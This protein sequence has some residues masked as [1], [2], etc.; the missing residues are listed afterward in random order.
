MPVTAVS[1]PNIALIKYWGNRNDDLRMPA[2]DSLSMTLDRPSVAV[3]VEAADV[4]RVRSFD[5]DGKERVLTGKQ[6]ARFAETLDLVREYLRTIHADEALPR[7][8]SITVRSHIP[9]SVGLASSAAVFSALARALAGLMR[10]HTPLTDAQVSVLARLG[11]GSA[12]RSI[13]GGYAALLAGDGDG[14]GASYGKHIAP[15][16]HW[17]L[18]DFV[19]IPSTEAKKVGSTEGH[20]LAQ[21]SP[22]FAQRIADIM[23]RRQPQCIDAVLRRDFELLRNVTEEDALDMHAVM[24]SSVPPLRYLSEETHRI[25]REITSLREEKHLP[26]LYTM[27]AGPTVHLL[28]EEGAVT[29][30]RHFA[31]AQKERGC[32]I[33]EAKTGEGTY[34]Q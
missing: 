15:S 29:D 25:I 9:S 11:S 12:A 4:F 32:V 34:L 6:V 2:A 3:T 1:Y 5:P 17:T 8:L 16:G 27:D 23:E 21:T 7:Q 24:E 14:I 13:F 33:F 18:Y 20:A 10:D 28:C 22:L 26:V 31:A 30:I 19:I